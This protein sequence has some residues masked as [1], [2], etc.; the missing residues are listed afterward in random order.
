MAG[1]LSFP[2][3]GYLYSTAATVSDLDSKR[4]TFVKTIVV[5]LSA[6]C[7]RIMCFGKFTG[8]SDRLVSNTYYYFSVNTSTFAITT[9]MGVRLAQMRMAR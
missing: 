6:L 5:V 8:S 3:Y 2:V 4:V 9:Y 7:A 1:H